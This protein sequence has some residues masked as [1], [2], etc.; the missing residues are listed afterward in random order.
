MDARIV[1]LKL[2]A[3]TLADPIWK[4]RYELAVRYSVMHTVDKRWLDDMLEHLVRPVPYDES[5]V[6]TINT[7]RVP[8]CE[9]TWRDRA[10]KDPLL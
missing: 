5:A 1:E 8:D 4:R 3:E 2:R 7:G 6:R 10:I 9:E